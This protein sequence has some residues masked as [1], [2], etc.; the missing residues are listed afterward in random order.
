MAVDR[1]KARWKADYAGTTYYFCC[2][3]CLTKFQAAPLQ[4]IGNSAEKPS[5]GLLTLAAMATA[6][7]AADAA[8]A[9]RDLPVRG[10]ASAPSADLVRDPVCGMK[11]D[12][13]KARWKT[14]YDGT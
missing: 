7:P 10:G 2:Q 8:P 4:Y 6:K 14:E 1:A 11:V 13:A 9:S 5:A 12:P 3:G